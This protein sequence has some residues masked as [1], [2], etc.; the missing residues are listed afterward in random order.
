MQLKFKNPGIEY[1]IEKIMEFQIDDSTDFWSDSLFYFY[2]QIDKGH[3]KNLP[4]SERKKYISDSLRGI[5]PE[6]KIV[7]DEK[8]NT[9]TGYWEEHKKQISDAL[10]EQFEI[11]CTNLFDDMVCNISMNPIAP[12][13]LKEH[14]FDVFYLNS[15][16]GALGMAIHEIIH[17]VWFYV[18][19]KTFRDSYD[20]YEKPSIKWILSEMI[21]ESVMRDE[22]LSSINPYFKRENGGCIYKYF[23]SLEIDGHF[24]I[25]ILEDMYRKNTISD[26]MRRSY[27]YCLQHE[28]EIREHII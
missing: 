13:Y 20:E 22:R 15:E 4:I 14:S 5:Y 3:A 11:D 12:R 10:S 21:V 24:V 25:D 23:Y 18:W 19:N 7:I 9:Y 26:F 27:S 2:P 6:I 28:K 8:I 17:F 16:K 1:M